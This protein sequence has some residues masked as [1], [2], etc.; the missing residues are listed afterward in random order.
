M[1]NN[2]NISDNSDHVIFHAWGAKILQPRLIALI[3]FILFYFIF[4][5]N[6]IKHV[7]VTL[8]DSICMEGQP[9]MC[10]FEYLVL[11]S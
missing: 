3:F 8:R 10:T 9:E 7:K 5:L 2:R 4:F 11:N 1:Y 6:E